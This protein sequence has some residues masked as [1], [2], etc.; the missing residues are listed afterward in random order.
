MT[1][2]PRWKIDVIYTSSRSPVARILS[3]ASMT[4]SS[5][6]FKVPHRTAGGWLRRCEVTLIVRFMLPACGGAI[7]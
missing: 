2:R 3:L 7:C 4:M 6:N 1:M 5:R